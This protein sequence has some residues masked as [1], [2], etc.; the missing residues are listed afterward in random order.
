[1]SRYFVRCFDDDLVVSL[2]WDE[3]LGTYFA[4]VEPPGPGDPDDLLLWAG[5]VPGEILEVNRLPVLVGPWANLKPSLLA[6]L[7]AD[8]RARR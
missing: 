5:T 7:Q 1:M 8:R 4:Q 2:G 3:P 6:Q